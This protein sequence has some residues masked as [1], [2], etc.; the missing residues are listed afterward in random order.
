MLQGCGGRGGTKRSYREPP[1]R[2]RQKTGR[3]RL[4]PRY[5]IPISCFYAIESD[6]ESIRVE[7]VEAEQKSA[8]AGAE[9]GE[10]RPAYRSIGTTQ[11]KV[12]QAVHDTLGT[13]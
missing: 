10:M 11:F 7:A 1:G 8:F 3:G 13:S 4:L 2:W 9:G 5:L 12:D 6:H